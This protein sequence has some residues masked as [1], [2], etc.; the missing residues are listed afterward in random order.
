MYRSKTAQGHALSLPFGKIKTFLTCSI[1]FLISQIG[2]SQTAFGPTAGET[3]G[4]LAS[5]S[6]SVALESGPQGIL[7][8]EP[9]NYKDRLTAFGAPNAL[10]IIPP[11]EPD[12]P[13]GNF[14]WRAD[15]QINNSGTDVLVQEPEMG[16]CCGFPT[17]Y[18]VPGPYPSAFNG[19]VTID[20]SEMITW[21]GSNDRDTDNQPFER[22]KVVFL[23]NGNVVWETSYTPD[24]A[25]LVSSAEWTGSLGG[26]FFPNGFDQIM[27]VHWEDTQYGNGP[28]TTPN[29]LSPASICINYQGCVLNA[30]VNVLPSNSSICALGSATL[31]ATASGGTTP[32]SYI[33]STGATVATITVSPNVTTAY[34]VTVSS[35]AGCSDTATRTVTV[36]ANPNAS[37]TGTNV[38]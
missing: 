38:I 2:I 21:D 37:I 22:L 16:T 4:S 35:P 34:T 13:S 20:I 6:P 24:L 7:G 3:L 25:D 5:L 12:C 10:L 9:S 28:E 27:F 31:T 15:I 36:Q 17:Q 23:R 32:Y 29:S 1:G 30:N 18:V 19:P 11:S 33:W 26:H 8:N 14:L